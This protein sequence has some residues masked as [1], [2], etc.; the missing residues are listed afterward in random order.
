MPEFSYYLIKPNAPLH[1]GESGVG[2]EETS[3]RLHSDTLFGAICWAWRLLYGEKDLIELLDLFWQARPPFL[4]SS[5]FPF[6]GK[7]MILPKP[8]DGLGP[9]GLEKKVRQ[10]PLISYSMFQ[11]LAQ[12]K[13]FQ[14]CSYGIIRGDPGNI[15]VSPQEDT[16]IK[17]MIGTGSAWTVGEAPRVILDRDNRRSDIYYAGDVRFMKDCGL[18]VLVDFLDASYKSKLEGALRLLGDEGLGGERSSG[19]GLF[20]LSLDQGPLSLGSNGGDRAVLLSLYRPR[21]EET[22]ILPG[23]SYGLITRRGWAAGKSDKRKRSVRMLVEGSV[24]P[25]GPENLLGSMEDVSGEGT[26]KGKRILSYGL[27]FKAPMRMGQ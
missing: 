15:I 20:T 14:D 21:L 1:I 26:R 7:T 5:T 2:L 13:S 8:L 24:I 6:I 25:C 22:S 9:A 11:S 18:Y 10:A 19:R 4:I 17:D 12:G 3:A 27:A 16:Q 23:S